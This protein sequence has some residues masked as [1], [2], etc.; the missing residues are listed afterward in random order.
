MSARKRA[1]SHSII[2]SSGG[3]GAGSIEN[4]TARTTLVLPLTLDQNLEGYALTVGVPK[5]ELIKRVLTE[6]L[7][8]KGLQPHKRPKVAIS[9]D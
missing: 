8:E 6:Y 1:P 3:S 4:G 7:K 9:Y 2:E 5:G